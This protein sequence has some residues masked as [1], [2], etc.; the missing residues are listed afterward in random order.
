MRANGNGDMIA[1]H[2]RGA[3]SQLRDVNVNLTQ[4][5]PM[6]A[7]VEFTPVAGPPVNIPQGQARTMFLDDLGESANSGLVQTEA[8]GT[9]FGG[10]V[11][12]GEI[13]LL[14]GMGFAVTGVD[15][16]APITTGDVEAMVSSISATMNLRERPVDLGSL[17]D[18]P[19]IEGVPGLPNNG[20]EIVGEVLFRDPIILQ[21][22][23]RF[24]IRLEVASQVNL[25]AIDIGPQVSVR[26]P[27]TRALSERVL[28]LS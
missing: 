18:W 10:R 5:R 24:S 2:V 16:A 26:L 14:H 28:A 22:L 21:P 3:L 12:N 6:T 25:S 17:S 15:G 23:D 19:S 1:Q 11:A 7:R 27:A 20:F 8:D 13:I 9:F 4:W